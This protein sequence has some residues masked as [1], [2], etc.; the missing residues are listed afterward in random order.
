MNRL[1]SICSRTLLI[2]LFFTLAVSS[3]GQE[4]GESQQYQQPVRI[5]IPAKSTDETYRVLPCGTSGALLFFKSIETI[6]DSMTKWFFSMYDQDLHQSWVRSIPVANGMTFQGWSP[7]NDT[8]SMLF[9][10]PGKE[11]NSRNNMYIL[12]VI[13]SKNIFITNSGT[14]PEE[15]EDIEFRVFHD[16]AFLCFNVKNDQARI[17]IMQLG[18]GIS[19]TLYWTK[20]L[21]SKVSDFK[22]DSSNYRLRAAVARVTTGKS[23][24]ENF[25]V[26]MDTTGR[27]F[28]EVPIQPSAQ[29]RFIRE[30]DF[31]QVDPDTWLAFGSYG[32]TPVK[33]NTKNKKI[34]ETTGFFSCKLKSGQP[35]D[36]TF[37][38]LLDLTN[39][40]EL[41]GDK[42]IMT[43]KK[44]ALKKNRNL[45]EYSLDYPMLLHKVF[46]HNDQFILVA[47]SFS[48]QYHSESFTDFDFY[49][50]P[51]VNT[52]EVFDGYRY[53]NG[54]VTAYNTDGKLLWDNSIEIRNLVSFDLTPRVNIFF[55]KDDEAVLAYLS[56]GKIASKIIHENSVVEKLDYSPLEMIHPEDKMLTETR[57]GM[58]SW[59]DNYF[60]CWGYEEIKNIANSDN[61]KRLVFFFC[62]IAFD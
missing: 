29:N 26:S 48:P 7:G 35:Y 24:M 28:A 49:G 57:S 13:L 42:D 52:Y 33:S 4:Q 59:Y 19:K 25:L 45:F 43:L 36:V 3:R 18:T 10:R 58:T 21:I 32:T 8:L 62:K 56:E 53:N 27:I 60:L 55:T 12:R 41:I 23:K 11:K 38:N 40:K 37:V 14:V 47:E 50:R 2:L 30:L 54:I 46:R 34:T 15:T 16:L 44:K 39:A 51:Y 20:G 5:E 22:A 9:I 61:P 1:K 6:G 17:Q 31:L